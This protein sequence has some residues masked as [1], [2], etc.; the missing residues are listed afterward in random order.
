MRDPAVEHFGI[1]SHQGFFNVHLNLSIW[2]SSILASIENVATVAGIRSHDLRNQPSLRAIVSVTP[3]VA[4]HEKSGVGD[5]EEE[6]RYMDAGR[7]DVV[8][9]VKSRP[10][11]PYSRRYRLSEKYTL[12]ENLEGTAVP[13]SGFRRHGCR[14]TV[15]APDSAAYPQCTSETSGQTF[16]WHKIG[17]TV[18]RHRAGQ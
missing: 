4:Y 14:G 2:D 13:V 9:P 8:H 11:F 18:C 5:D 16:A 15:T 1:Q 3:F 12:S 10:V 17:R 6:R 7:W